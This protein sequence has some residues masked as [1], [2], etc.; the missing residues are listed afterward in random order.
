MRHKIPEIAERRQV[1]AEHGHLMENEVLH[2]IIAAVFV[3]GQRVAAAVNAKRCSDGRAIPVATC[4][5]RG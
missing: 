1:T 5:A 4:F 2:E 3:P